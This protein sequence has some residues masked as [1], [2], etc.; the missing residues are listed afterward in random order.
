[1]SLIFRRVGSTKGTSPFRLIQLS[2]LL[3]GCLDTHQHLA[4]KT[5]DEFI[6]II[7]P[8]IELAINHPRLI[9]YKH[10]GGPL[11]A[12]RDQNSGY[13]IMIFLPS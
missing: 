8:D 7:I 4:D 6:F 13:S 9:I 1:M 3:I 11:F 10:D 2:P 12:Y 5:V